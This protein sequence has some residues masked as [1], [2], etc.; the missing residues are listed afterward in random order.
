M[1][2]NYGDKRTKA[3]AEGKRV[4]AFSGFERSAR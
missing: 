1:I 2:V 4:R 3:F